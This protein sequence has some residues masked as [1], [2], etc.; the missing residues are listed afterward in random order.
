MIDGSSA[1]RPHSGIDA[2]SAVT[3]DDGVKYY[4]LILDRTNHQVTRNGVVILKQ[5]DLP[6]DANGNPVSDNELFLTAIARKPTAEEVEVAERI[7]KANRNQ[8]AADIL[9]ALLDTPEFLLN[10]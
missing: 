1:S 2:I 3:T 8:G 10:Y 7:I 9:W 4:Q 5:S 6:K